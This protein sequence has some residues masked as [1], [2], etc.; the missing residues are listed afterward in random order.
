MN[1]YKFIFLLTLSQFVSVFSVF[2]TTTGEPLV[3]KN[4]KTTIVLEDHLKH[5]LY[6]WP[7]TV[8]SYD[9]VFEEAVSETQLELT[10]PHSGKQL[11]FQITDMQNLPQGK[12][13]GRLHIMSGLNSKEKRAYI[14]QK[15]APQKFPSVK[16]TEQNHYYQVQTEK[17]AVRIPASQSVGDSSIPAPVMAISMNGKDWMGNSF[18]RDT[19]NR[20]S[21][22]K[23]ETKR[24]SEGPLFAA[25]ELHYTFSNEAEYTAVIRC[26]EGYEFVEIRE[27]MEGFPE[28][29]SARW[30]IDW[31]NFKP[32]HRQAPN[33]PYGSPKETGKGFT[34]YDWETVDQTMLNSHH[35]IIK[36]TSSDGKIPFEAG[37][38]G[39][40][41]AELNVTSTLFWNEETDQ[42]VGI[43][44]QD[45]EYWDNRQYPIWHDSR[46]MSVK[47]YYQDQLLRWS[48]PLIN[49]TRAT[50][51]SIYPH[52][53]DIDYM[54][55]L[56]K[57]IQSNKTPDGYTCQV[58][59]SQYSHNSFLQNRYGTIDMNKVK[60]WVLFYSDTTSFPKLYFDKSHVYSPVNLEH[61]FYDR[62]SNALP[63]SGPCQ[64]SGYG[65]PRGFYH[66]YTGMM[67]GLLPYIPAEQ[68][69]R[70]IAMFL[71]HT[72]IAAGED[73]MPM[74][75]MFSGHPNFLS[76]VKTVPSFAAFLFPHHPKAEEWK[77]LFEKY[78]DLNSHYHSR[79][80][81][82]SWDA[83]GG[84]WTENI[85]TYVWGFLRP[86][87][88]ANY[89]LRETDGKN[90]MANANTSG[91]AAYMLNTLSAPFNGEAVEPYI[92]E[93][94][95]RE[96]HSWGLVTKET[97]PKRLIPTQGA[98][99]IRRSMPSGY[100]L[101]G[102]YLEYYDPLLSEN[103][104]YVARPEYEDAE[105]IYRDKNAF[106][107][108]YPLH[109]D[110]SGTPPDLQSVKI[111]GYGIILRTA[112]GTKDELSI[113]L[114][115]I[116][117]GQNYRWGIVG[118]GG[119]GSIY[120]Y[121]GGESYSNN[122]RE[123]VGDRRLQDTDLVTGFGVFKD[124]RFKS[125][126]RNELTRP[127]Y[128]LALGQFA[129]IVS[130]KESGYSWPEY[131]GRSI[132]LVGSDYFIVYDDVY[133][134]N[135][136][137]RFS[138][139][140]HPA[141]NLPELQAIKSGGAN[142][143]YTPEPPERISVSGRES[144]GV[145]FDGTGDMM[146]FVSHKKGYKSK[147]MPYGCIIT[148]PTG[149]TDYIFRNEVPVDVTDPD[150][151]FSGTAGFLRTLLSGQELAI[152]HGSR[153]GNADF[154]IK[155][156]DED[157]GLS[158]V[159]TDREHIS[160]RYYCLQEANVTFRWTQGIPPALHF[161][162]DGVKQD[163]SLQDN[164]LTVGFPKGKHLWT[165][166]T[167]LPDI[168]RPQIDYT[169]N[170]KGKVE[171]AVQPVAGAQS[172]RCEYSTD[173]ETWTV[174]KEQTGHLFVFTPVGKETKGYIRITAVNREKSGE[175][176]VI[177]PV[178]YTSARPHYP[179]GLKLKI[180]EK[181]V[182]ATWGKVLGCNNYRLYRRVRGGSY[183]PVYTGSGNQ[184]VD[185]F[186]ATSRI[187]EYAVSTFNG[188]GESVLCNAV[189]TDP[190]NW[191][192][193]EPVK[194]E[195]FRRTVT[196]ES[197]V[198]ND[199]NKMSSSYYPE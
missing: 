6:W 38:Y 65:P 177:Y 11:P 28:R 45:I 151:V 132:M 114:G 22:R 53:K 96:T 52:Q 7:Q 75:H 179:D 126:G 116:D 79:P 146:T 14:L 187:Y 118:E 143:V 191:L 157:A 1:L 21:V 5:P 110:D 162:L 61:F 193:F 49:G 15:G 82:K 133:N 138:W 168:P 3:F 93:K 111:T 44:V 90:R 37:I 92:N 170:N 87:I 161:Y 62:Y 197:S 112:V 97:G 54:D 173:A 119:C 56:E 156:Q 59:M 153:I 66:A 67:N 27:Q 145:W 183:K 105:M 185:K 160:G 83:M 41:P 47:F 33:H 8:L 184:Y 147:P 23:L 78:I 103:M 165:L 40:W 74:K 51:L 188:N 70:M 140:T 163:V 68:R 73:Q 141:D 43:F 25:F 149:V 107:F 142:Y 169:R 24:I 150:R 167:G 94:G 120:F 31:V 199:G 134:R 166:T 63:T 164:E 20:V 109:T 115:Q 48:Y 10:D 77:D 180:D 88:R 102:K 76:D 46:I 18:F 154:E 122:G 130:S 159:F 19:S 155:P 171:L 113:H 144:K 30:E 104:R 84:R 101:F 99:S 194:G 196:I 137:T 85:N 139:L 29:S 131:A 148:S 13:R 50:A 64:N 60:D 71:M 39:N 12:K 17:Y 175:P 100:W 2:S 16:I 192:N 108:M 158:A 89:L 198:D 36:N 42:S 128:D 35:G 182:T 195:P 190:D 26:V 57:M 189:T 176:S 174:Q 106:N 81:V 121:A 129:E 69:N 95:L 32:T 72:Y 178:Y 4:G 136:A 186:P 9:I 124:G 123:D 135:M 117:N 80:A 91:I 34:R 172:Y 181:Q 86:A 125:I 127:M 58:E 152:F 55:N 98:H